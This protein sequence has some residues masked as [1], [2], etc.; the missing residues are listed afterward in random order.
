MAP[1]LPLHIPPGWEW[2]S[3]PRC[4]HETYGG[5]I[6][7]HGSVQLK[8]CEPPVSLT[9]FSAWAGLASQSLTLI[10]RTLGRPGPPSSHFHRQGS[11]PARPLM[12]ALTFIDEALGLCGHPA[13]IFI[14]RGFSLLSTGPGQ[15]GS[16]SL[17]SIGQRLISIGK[18]RPRQSRKL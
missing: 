16:Q 7:A 12:Q 6:A 3:K 18:A 13:V 5:R 14:D 10:S 9:K 2:P 17:T 8:T 1:A 11:R 15:P 4:L